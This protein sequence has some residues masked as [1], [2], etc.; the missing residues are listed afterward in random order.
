MAEAHHFLKIAARAAMEQVDMLA[1]LKAEEVE[2]KRREEEAAKN[3]KMFTFGGKAKQAD[4]AVVYKID[5]MRN[6]SIAY[7]L[8]KASGALQHSQRQSIVFQF[9]LK[10]AKKAK[11]HTERQRKDFARLRARALRAVDWCNFQDISLM[12]LIRTGLN[13]DLL[14]QRRDE[15]TTFLLRCGRNVLAADG[16]RKV[17]LEVR[18]YYCPIA[19]YCIVIG[20]PY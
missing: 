3:A 15:A 6:M 4:I 14:V 11:S 13:C 17:A 16:R 5:K 2:R 20:N 12:T 1:K 9:F 10:L 8:A 18:L 19:C 7:L